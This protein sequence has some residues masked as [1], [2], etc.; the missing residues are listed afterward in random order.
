M[1]SSSRQA[2]GA[3][4]G[5]KILASAVAFVCVGAVFTVAPQLAA[6]KPHTRSHAHRA[7]QHKRTHQHKHHGAQGTRQSPLSLTELA[8][9]PSSG[10][11]LSNTRTQPLE[12]KIG[13]SNVARLKP[14]WVFTTHGNVSATPTVVDGVV[15][16]PDWGGYI[17]AVEAATGKLIWQRQMSSYD[18][19][20]GSFSRVSPAVYGNELI[21]GDNFDELEPTGAHLYAVNRL[22]G[23]PIWSAHLDPHQAAIDTG[24]PEVVDNEVIVGVSSSEEDAAALDTYPCCTFR[25]S[26]VAL[27]AE[28][29]QQLWKTYTVPA[30]N[31]PCTTDNPPSGCGYSGGAIWGTPSVAPSI[32][33]VFVGTGNNYTAP[34]EANACEE[35][36]IETKTSDEYCTAPND[37]FDSILSL[38]L[39]TGQ[40]NWGHK[41]EGWDATSNACVGKEKRS[42]TWCPSLS[43]PDFDFG[44]NG[45]NLI[46]V[47]GKLA[48]GDGQKSGVYWVLN[49]ET[50]QIMWDTLVGPGGSLGGIEWG[51]AADTAS[52]F[53]PLSDVYKAPYRLIGG[54]EDKGG[55]WAALNPQTGAF[56]WQV[57]TPG[58]S[59][60]FGPPSEANGVLYA[61]DMNA[62]AN[63]MFALNAA[64]GKI[65]WRFASGGS[66]ASSPAIVNGT[67]YWGSGYSIA[68]LIGNT[69]KLYAFTLG[70]T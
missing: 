21:F 53:V 37:Y 8:A 26:V 35:K 63:N 70:G 58:D 24:N 32:N 2:A 22:D 65:L 7:S 40:I 64:T 10:Q 16:F 25:G 38:N 49:A 29:G 1:R 52:V 20:S 57:P 18:G 55:S 56:Q 43:S 50:G 31:G 30:N 48:V 34:D 66:V 60:A 6:A 14:K 54:E 45:P 27:N 47:N 36:A 69:D 51:S 15:Y 41:V 13:A 5:R 44:G 67:V 12:S 3:V 59:A 39:T 11:N 62:F 9:W 33:A 17:N 61:G 68:G 19:V 42:R 46:R 4:R 28:T 23:E